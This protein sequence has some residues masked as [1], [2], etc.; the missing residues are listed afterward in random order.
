MEDY[1]HFS[2]LAVSMASSEEKS[3]SNVEDC[4][5]SATEDISPATASK[6]HSPMMIVAKRPDTSESHDTETFLSRYV[7]EP[8]PNS[9]LVLVRSS[10]TAS[11]GLLDA[12]PFNHEFKIIQSPPLHRT[13]LPWHESRHVIFLLGR[14]MV[15]KSISIFLYFWLCHYEHGPPHQNFESADLRYLL[16]FNN[17]MQLLEKIVTR[18]WSGDKVGRILFEAKVVT[19]WNDGQQ[20]F[21]DLIQLLLLAQSRA[22]AMTGRTERD[23]ANWIRVGGPH[24]REG[25]LFFRQLNYEDLGFDFLLSEFDRWNNA[26]W[27]WLG[28]PESESLLF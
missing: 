13:S 19:A 16:N 26:C 4:I 14:G 6:N 20:L 1:L 7:A 12:L 17:I 5:T 11:M 23:P 3:N 8:P 2:Q 27:T 24:E 28:A 18:W 25:K 15:A 21:F 9:D 22:F 10:D